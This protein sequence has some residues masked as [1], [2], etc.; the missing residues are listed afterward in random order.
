MCKTLVLIPSLDNEI[1][2]KQFEDVLTERS[3]DSQVP[4]PLTDFDDY[5]NSIGSEGR[6]II[7]LGDNRA[8]EQEVTASEGFYEDK[9]TAD[10][11]DDER[12]IESEEDIGDSEE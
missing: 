6:F 3:A 9:A 12:V 10:S 2:F 8:A 1:I 4:A 5:S 7:A 11:M